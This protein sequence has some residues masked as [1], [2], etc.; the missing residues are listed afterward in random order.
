[1]KASP[2]LAAALNLTIFSSLLA[3]TPPQNPT[4]P[5][6]GEEEVVRV[7]TNLVQ[8]DAV[9]TDKNGNAVKDLRAEDFEIL[10]DGKPQKV[11]ACSY[12]SVVS[13]P[14]ISSTA[15][16]AEAVKNAPPLPPNPLRPEQ[17]RRTIV[18]VIDD[19]ALTLQS[20][21]TVKAG[22]KK[23]V[24][25][26]MQ[27]GD[28][29]AI[30]R[31]GGGSGA[32][33]RLTSDKQQLYAAIESVRWRRLYNRAGSR[34]FAPETG[35]TGLEALISIKATLMALKNI[36]SSL[37]VLPGRK[38]VVFFTDNF[39][40]FQNPADLAIGG[41]TKPKP[42]EA[43]G[44]SGTRDMPE[45]SG[46][47]GGLASLSSQ[48]SVVIY[49]VDARGLAYTGPRAVDASPTGNIVSGGPWGPTR[50]GKLDV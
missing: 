48:A 31:T 9:V 26:Q 5:K 18:F 47:F 10:E 19:L 25:E 49:P 12:I 42:G 8:V 30:V 46:L 7:T 2:F 27:P 22:L 38:G 20:L 3:Q 4:Q 15:T 32:L 29:A 44:G 16:A 23:F 50:F 13:K 45:Y 37:K 17:V 36:V 34:V 14:T 6:P 21:N 35:A 43:P 1:M 28:L 40:V 33:Q 24:G 39:E 11:T 41:E